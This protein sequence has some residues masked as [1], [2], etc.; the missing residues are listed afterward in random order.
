M[1]DH[2]PAAAEPTARKILR[3]KA[4]ELGAAGARDWLIQLLSASPKVG[5]GRQLAD[6]IIVELFAPAQPADPSAP[7]APPPAPPPPAGRPFV[8]DFLHNWPRGPLF[9][10][11]RAMSEGDFRAEIAWQVSKGHT[12]VTPYFFNTGDGDGKH[13]VNV[14]TERDLARQRLGYIIQQGLQAWPILYSDAPPTVDPYAAVESVRAF[15][16]LLTGIFTFLEPNDRKNDRL[17]QE[18]SESVDHATDLPV[19]IHTNP[20]NGA[21]FDTNLRFARQPWCQ[22]VG[23]EYSNPAKPL[24]GAELQRLTRKA[25]DAL[26]GKTIIGLE[27]GFNRPDLGKYILR[28]GAAGVGGGLDAEGWAILNGISVPTVPPV[29]PPVAGALTFSLGK[30]RGRYVQWA[31]AVDRTGWGEGSQEGCDGLLY[32]CLVGGTPR[33]VEH[34]KVGKQ[35]TGLKNAYADRNDRKYNQGWKAGDRVLLQ[36]RDA[37]GKLRSPAHQGEWTL[38]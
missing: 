17:V 1:T 9:L 25:V 16:H 29:A 11:S 6:E 5:D 12:A 37:K 13:P 8:T 14:L 18:V 35:E 34:I 31:P 32:G 33:K 21:S 27:W 28:G 22:V 23:L 15:G 2:I 24:S 3:Q 30:A 19:G 10:L 36:L 4:K 38:R 26:P 20:I 7:G